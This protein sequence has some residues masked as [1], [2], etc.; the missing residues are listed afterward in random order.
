M[1]KIVKGIVFGTVLSA[2]SMTLWQM[3]NA[4]PQVT[5]PMV[6]KPFIAADRPDTPDFVSTVVSTGKRS[7]YLFRG[8]SNQPAPNTYNGLL[9]ENESSLI[10][11]TVST[12][13]LEYKGNPN[14]DIV[15]NYNRVPSRIQGAAHLATAS[16]PL[17]AGTLVSS[18][19]D[20]FKKVSFTA[21]QLGLPEFNSIQKIAVVPPS[22]GKSKLQVDSVRVNFAEVNKAM[23]SLFFTVAGGSG[24]GPIGPKAKAAV[25]GSPANPTDV[26]LKNGSGQPVVAWLTLPTVCT[27]NSQCI[28]DVKQIFP[29]MVCV[30][31]GCFQGSQTLQ[32]GQ[33]V[34][35]SP[36]PNPPGIQGALL[37]FINPPNCGVTNAEFTLNNVSQS[38]Q[39]AQETVNLSVVNGNNASI[40]FDL[41]DGAGAQWN[42]NFG[43][44][45][46][47]GNFQNYAGD[48]LNVV[49]V[50]PK[51]CTNCSFLSG[52][53]V[54]GFTPTQC[55]GP[56]GSICQPPDPNTCPQYC[57][58]Q[59]PASNPGGKVTITYLGAPMALPTNKGKLQKIL[60]PAP[61]N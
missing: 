33:T 43:T 49:G 1:R 5:P 17:S 22:Q 57:S 41:N 21:Q 18:T 26:I 28:L 36:P 8:M 50:F 16:V 61:R 47:K 12:F 24:S 52:P 15:V 59:R 32:P 38:A 53:P 7:P 14:S 40:Q 55:S 46:Y 39:F 30:T 44:V 2:W 54:C 58:Y 4:T 23:Q 35:Y 45:P 31:G 6:S 3:V 19:P 48:N 13:D 9:I 11:A 37:S 25:K 10:P 27:P 42:T 34:V 20:G 60:A 56:N 29:G 51:G